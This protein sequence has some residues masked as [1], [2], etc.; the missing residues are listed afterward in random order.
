MTDGT[1]LPYG[2]AVSLF[3]RP[4]PS[5]A[6]QGQAQAIGRFWAWWQGEGSTQTALAI[7]DGQSERMVPV[8]NEKVSAIHS[9][10]SWELAAGESSQHVLIV[11]A[12]GDPALRPV[13]R[14]WRRAAPEPDGIWDYADS[15]P[16][17]AD[18][19]GTVLK[20]GDTDVALTEATAGARVTGVQVDVSVY[21]PAFEQLPDDARQLATFLLL[22][23]V[24]GELA[25]ETWIGAIS[26]T[27]APPLD[28]VPL[29]GLRAV[30][31]DLSAQ[32]TDDKG[33]PHW[34]VAEGLAKG[35]R[36]LVSMQ[37]PLRAA[38]APDLDTHVGVQVPFSD[39]TPDALP[40][41]GSLASLRRFED[42]LTARLDGSGR[43]V[44]HV[45]HGG[46]RVLHFYVD[47]TTP[48]ADQLRAAVKGWDQ[49]PVRV[50][51]A[52]DPGW[53]HVSHLR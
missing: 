52:A 4:S 29:A 8:L 31:R 43:L 10:L 48:A 22:D 45:T 9:G 39:R 49:G 35:S 11:S 23:A 38:S 33:D 30:V 53:S 51:V 5:R 2:G 25:V 15:R 26:T 50:Q 18:P 44:A 42:H 6:A 21:H 1:R 37:I 46:M 24:L 41:P 7:L 17:V 20:I 16:P 34:V 28:A 47:G 13:A 27:T 36:V 40:G 19:D 3:R 14:R 12:E 32:F